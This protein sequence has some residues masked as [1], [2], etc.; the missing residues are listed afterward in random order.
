MLYCVALLILSLAPGDQLSLKFLSFPRR[1]QGAAGSP[2]P[3][4]LPAFSSELSHLEA[5]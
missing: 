1:L 3:Q 4:I 5:T 2:N